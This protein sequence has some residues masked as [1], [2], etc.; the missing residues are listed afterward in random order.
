[1][2]EPEVLLEDIM[3]LAS[4]LPVCPERNA[5]EAAV[6]AMRRRLHLFDGQDAS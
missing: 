3:Q 6:T 5:I 1:M 4:E 2:T